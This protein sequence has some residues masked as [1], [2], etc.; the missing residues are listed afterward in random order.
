MDIALRSYP[1]LIGMTAALAI[2][3]GILSRLYP[4]YYITSFPPA[5]VLKGS[6]GLSPK[7]RK[8]RNMLITG[9]D[10]GGRIHVPPKP[11]HARLSF[12]VRQGRAHRYRYKQ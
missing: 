11:V 2:L 10:D 9:V 12:G 5:V 7:G 8:L 1:V 6:F 3:T 4:A